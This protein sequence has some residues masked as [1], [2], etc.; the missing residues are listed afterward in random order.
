MMVAGSVGTLWPANHRASGRNRI[1]MIAIQVDHLQD[2]Q[3]GEHARS[4]SRT[5]S[6]SIPIIKKNVYPMATANRTSTADQ[7]DQDANHR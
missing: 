2:P 6:P 5:L 1:E 3:A 7:R 4:R